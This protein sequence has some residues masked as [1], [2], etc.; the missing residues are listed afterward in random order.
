MI[1]FITL[2]LSKFILYNYKVVR[3]K[4]IGINYLRDAPRF[5]YVFLVLSFLVLDFLPPVG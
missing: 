3:C 2:S 1:S 5:L 4:N